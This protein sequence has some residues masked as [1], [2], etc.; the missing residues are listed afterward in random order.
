MK[1]L[2]R[3]KYEVTANDFLQIGNE[4]DRF[5]I[6][7]LEYDYGIYLID[8]LTPCKEAAIRIVCNMN[9]WQQANN[10]GIRINAYDYERM[11]VEL[12]D[13][14]LLQKKLDEYNNLIDW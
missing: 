14:Q 5:M 9:E 8:E 10:K 1:Q 4:L 6:L 2:T 13:I 7:V 3:K 12:Y 11:S